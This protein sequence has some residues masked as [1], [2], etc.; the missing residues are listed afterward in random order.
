MG[1]MTEITKL[2]RPTVNMIEEQV[3]ERLAELSEELGVNLN[4]SGGTFSNVEATLKLKIQVQN[5]D[6]GSFYSKE[7]EDFKRNAHLI[8]MKPDDLGKTFKKYG[9]E[10]FTIEGFRIRA[11][12]A[13]IL[14]KK[15]SNGK[16][17]AFSVE[18]V[19]FHLAATEKE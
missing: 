8:G 5:P 19:K 7:G 6:T 15:T 10:E 3:N 2:D 14:A 17:F 18:S 9:Q 4:V 1:T 11:R 13:P 12:K 16:M